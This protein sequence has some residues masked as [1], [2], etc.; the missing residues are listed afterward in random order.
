ML[1]HFPWYGLAPLVLLDGKLTANQYKVILTDQL[2]PMMKHF[3]PI[4]RGLFQEDSA[5]STGLAGL[6]NGLK[7]KNH[8]LCPSHSS[9]LNPFGLLWEILDSALYHHHEKTCGNI[10]W[11]NCPRVFAKSFLAPHGGKTLQ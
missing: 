3:Y 9:D 8:I 1:W 10:L 5:P 7:R 6:P 4:G 11:K 2:Y